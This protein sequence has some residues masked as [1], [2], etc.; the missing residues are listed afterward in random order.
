MMFKCKLC[1][2]EFTD[3]HALGGH[4]RKHKTVIKDE[5]KERGKK[6]NNEIIEKALERLSDI[7]P[8]EAWQIVVNWIMDVYRQTQIRDDIIQAYR[9]RVEESE[10]KI[11]AIQSQLRRLRQMVV[12][13]H[14]YK[15]TDDQ[16]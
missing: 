16:L 2:A 14:I 4:M 8:Q 11:E 15:A 13:G 3:W 10:S 12:D 6:H 7:S 9:M 1:E 5:K